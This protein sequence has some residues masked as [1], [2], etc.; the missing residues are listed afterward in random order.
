MICPP[1]K[2]DLSEVTPAVARAAGRRAYSRGLDLE[3]NPYSPTS[4][5]GKAWKEG[6]LDAWADAVCKK[7]SL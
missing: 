3:H 6:F 2:I 7:G 1:P 5:Q 4:T